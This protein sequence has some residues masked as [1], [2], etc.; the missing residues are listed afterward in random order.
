MSHKDSTIMSHQIQE[1]EK[2]FNISVSAL[3]LMPLWY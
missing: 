2:Q 3:L 1:W